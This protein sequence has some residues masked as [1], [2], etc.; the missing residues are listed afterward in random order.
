MVGWLVIWLIIT[1]FS[2]G[3]AIAIKLSNQIDKVVNSMNQGLATLNGLRVDEPV[4]F[5]DIRDPCAA[6]YCPFNPSS[7]TSNVP[8]S[9]KKKLVQLVCLQDRCKEEQT[10]LEQEMLR[11]SNFLTNQVSVI[12]SYLETGT[13][14][15][16]GLMSLLLQKADIHRK[17]LSLLRR[18]CGHAVTFPP[19]EDPGETYLQFTSLEVERPDEVAIESLF[20]VESFED[21]YCHN[22]PIRGWNDEDSD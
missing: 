7:E 17:N 4:T 22:T 5:G 12:T 9:V 8:L 18:T 15:D 20:D 21:L 10:L 6:I 13:V 19:F 3:Q 11:F 1:F 14:V 2:D 16:R